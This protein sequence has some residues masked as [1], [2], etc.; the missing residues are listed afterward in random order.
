MNPQSISHLVVALGLGLGV[1]SFG[2]VTPANA[3]SDILSRLADLEAK[4][5]SSE[6]G[7]VSRFDSEVE[8]VE[9]ASSQPSAFSS[10]Q[11]QQD[12]NIL[13]V[14]QTLEVRGASAERGVSPE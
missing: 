3:Q 9:V 13:D 1:L 8:G 10:V 2:N 6:S 4:G 5:A 14:L 11:Q 12:R 7:V